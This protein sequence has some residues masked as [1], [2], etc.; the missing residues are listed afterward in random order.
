MLV[1]RQL[2]GTSYDSTFTYDEYEPPFLVSKH[3]T[4]EEIKME[5]TNG[6]KDVGNGTRLTQQLKIKHNG[7]KKLLEPFLSKRIEKQIRINIDKLKL[8]YRL[9][10]AAGV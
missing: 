2:L 5:I 6:L 7:P 4:S 3:I 8:Y 10:S 1:L 9:K